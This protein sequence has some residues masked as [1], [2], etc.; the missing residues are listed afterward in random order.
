MTSPKDW[1]VARYRERPGEGRRFIGTL[2]ELGGSSLA[3]LLAD[4]GW[5]LG[6]DTLRVGEF[7]GLAMARFASREEAQ[8]AIE[9]NR[10]G[11]G[12]LSDVPVHA[13]SLQWEAVWFTHRDRST[14]RLYDGRSY[15]EARVACSRIVLP[16]IYETGWIKCVACGEDRSISAGQWG[17]S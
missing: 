1:F 8:A 7:A 9:A 6:F 13:D 2:S 11:G 17:A 10:S 5:T 14:R 15:D 4:I 3:P 12:D 16:E